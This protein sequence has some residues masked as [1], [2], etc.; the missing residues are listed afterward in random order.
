MLS[1]RRV[2]LGVSGGI[3]AYKSVYLARTL[4]TSGAEVRVILTRAARRFVGSQSFA[5]VTGEYP[6]VGIFDRRLVSPHTEL[7]RWCEA[8]V[9]APATANTLAKLAQGLSADLLSATYLATR[10]P[11]LLAPAMH[12]EMWEQHATGRNISILAADGC[13]LVGPDVGPLAGGDEGEGRMAEPEDILAALAGILEGPMV[14]RRVLVTA[15]GT[16]ESIDPVRFIGNRSSGRMG[17]AVAEEAA[18]RG[19]DVV[20]ITTAEGSPVAGVE[21]VHVESAAEMADEVWSRCHS[22]D[23]VVMTAAVADFRPKAPHGVKLR[24][25]AGPP[26]LILEPTPDILA[27]VRERA[28]DSYVV[29][30]AAETGPPSQ[31]AEKARSKGVQLLVANDVTAEGSGFG[32]TTNQVVVFGEDGDSEQWPL[33]PKREVARRLLDRITAEIDG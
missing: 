21:T 26:E 3:A 4:V 25:E 5:A 9:I 16:R 8:L 11:V 23:V 22:Q 6:Y 18:A 13:H 7:A 2:L 29:G 31:A 27:G 12:T 32:T 20:L 28:P 17:H 10:A 24:R 19:A 33:L 1:D 14:G 30:F 15:G